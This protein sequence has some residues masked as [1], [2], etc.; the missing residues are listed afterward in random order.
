MGGRGGGGV[1]EGGRGA[2]Q[3][4]RCG[5]LGGCGYGM[6]TQNPGRCGGDRWSEGNAYAACEHLAQYR[7]RNGTESFR[8]LQRAVRTEASGRACIKREDEEVPQ[9]TSCGRA[10][11]RLYVC[12]V[13]A[14][15]GCWGETQNGRDSGFHARAH[16]MSHPGHG[17]AVDIERAELFCCLCSDQVYDWDFDR[18]IIGARSS[19]ALRRGSNAG[20]SNGNGVDIGRGEANG[21]EKLGDAQAVASLAVSSLG[22]RG[23]GY[24]GNSHESRKR[25]RGIDHTPWVPSG[26][27]QLGL[28]QSSTSLAADKKLPAGLRGLNNLGNTCFMNS[29]LQALL[30]TPP[31]RNYFLS[32]R[33]NRA[34]CQ[35]RAS[36]LCLGCDMDTIFTAAFSGERSPYSPAQFLYRCYFVCSHGINVTIALDFE[37]HYSGLCDVSFLV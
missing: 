21:C 16:A 4:A 18:A 3:G 30:H 26:R 15:I 27:E 7:Q 14:N 36:H 10:R 2:G 20:E 12:L 5:C 1:G 37:F 6:G 17:L 8:G 24:C 9:C 19:A 25:R 23:E 35:K 31:L 33:H 22:A 32:D 11:G 34:L 28:K 13:C 29:V